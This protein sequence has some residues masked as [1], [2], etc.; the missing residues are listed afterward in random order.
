M[1]AQTALSIWTCPGR[2]AGKLEYGVER[3]WGVLY[4]NLHRGFG[5]GTAALEVAALNCAFCKASEAVLTFPAVFWVESSP[6][7]PLGQRKALSLTRELCSVTALPPVPTASS[8]TKGAF[9]KGTL[10]ERLRLSLCV[11]RSFPKV[12]QGSMTVQGGEASSYLLYSRFNMYVP[13]NQQTLK[14]IA[15]ATFSSYF[16]ATLWLQ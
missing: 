13:T 1:Q 12:T 5:T 11:G 7:R 15:L 2:Q 8:W 6:S 14:R 16:P 9:F 4:R 3:I 10:L